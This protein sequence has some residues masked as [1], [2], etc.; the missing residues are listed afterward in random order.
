M[1]NLLLSYRNPPKPTFSGYKFSEF[2]QPTFSYYQNLLFSLPEMVGVAIIVN[3]TK[4]WNSSK[5]VA[6]A[7]LGLVEAHVGLG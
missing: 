5:L 2:R 7:G 1:K 3:F 6:N 4:L